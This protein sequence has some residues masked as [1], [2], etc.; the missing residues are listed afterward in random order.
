MKS[1]ICPAAIGFA[2]GMLGAFFR[3][4]MTAGAKHSAL[5]VTFAQ[6]S[7]M[8]LGRRS[9]MI[10]WSTALISGTEWK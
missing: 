7:N 5:L 2:G 4:V 6:N 8:G 3:I 10:F 9:A 1:A